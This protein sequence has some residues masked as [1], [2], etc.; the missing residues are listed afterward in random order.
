M[1]EEHV[2]K[3]MVKNFPRCPVCS[4]EGHYTVSPSKTVVQC[5]S[6]KTKFFSEDFKDASRQLEH[7][8]LFAPPTELTDELGIASLLSLKNQ[9]FS[10]N[11][12]KNMEYQRYLVRCPMCRYETFNIQSAPNNATMLTCP[13]CG[14][15]Y[16]L[17]L[18]GNKPEIVI[19]NL[20]SDPRK[21]GLRLEDL[22]KITSPE[23]WQ[24]FESKRLETARYCQKCNKVMLHAP[25]TFRIGPLQGRLEG[26]LLFLVFGEAGIGVS[27]HQSLDTLT[28]EVYACPECRQ[29]QLS[30]PEK[31]DKEL[32]KQSSTDQFSSPSP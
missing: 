8:S 12:W 7:L 21:L 32:L 2:R 4:S 29:V 6:C 18:T 1:S 22:Q 5:N 24:E 28:L 10:V 9:R 13:D 26:S 30:L 3:L 27:D 31:G 17:T 19:Q 25:V 23:S 16:R 15:I 14:A 20:G 11:F